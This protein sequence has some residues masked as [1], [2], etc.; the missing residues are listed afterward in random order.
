MNKMLAINN[1]IGRL[2]AKGGDGLTAFAASVTAESGAISEL[3][4]QK[5]YGEACKL[6]DEI[7]AKYKLNLA[8]EQEEMISVEQLAKD[9]GKG[10]GKCSVADAAKMQME[11]HA[12]LQTEVTAGRMQQDI[13]NR[14][15]N[16]TKDYASLLSTNPGKACELFEKL[17]KDYGL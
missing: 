16:D 4:A 17:K 3:I 10:A 9:G 8:A 5:K 2:F 7:A 13:F 14:F 12:S 1:M 6:A 15:N 11:L